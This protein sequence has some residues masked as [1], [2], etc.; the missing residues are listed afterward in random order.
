[1]AA[2]LFA[3]AGFVRVSRPVSDFYAAGRLMPAFLNSMAIAG[4]SVAALAFAGA[5]GAV[6]FDWEGV[7]VLLCGVGAGLIVAGL[8]VAPYLRA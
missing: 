2:L 3:R 8:V 7:S 4:S 1:M 6:D 5:S